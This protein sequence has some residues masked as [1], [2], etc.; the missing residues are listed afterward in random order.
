MR[1]I[2]YVC[3]PQNAIQGKLIKSFNQHLNYPAYTRT[4]LL[5]LLLSLSLSFPLIMGVD[6]VCNQHVDCFLW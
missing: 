6:R 2:A 1:A 5:A 4:L 3:I